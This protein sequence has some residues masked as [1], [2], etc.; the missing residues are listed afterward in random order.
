MISSKDKM[1]N[2][3]QY[4]SIILSY[5]PTLKNQAFIKRILTI[6]SY[7]LIPILSQYN[8]SL[9]LYESQNSHLR[10]NF[11]SITYDELFFEVNLRFLK[12]KVKGKKNIFCFLI[13]SNFKKY[14][15]FIIEFISS[16]PKNT[17]HYFSSSPVFISK[18]I[19]HNNKNFVYISSYKPQEFPLL[20]LKIAVD[21]PI[22][23]VLNKKRKLRIDKNNNR[24]EG[25]TM[26]CNTRGIWCNDNESQSSNED[27]EE[28][29]FARNILIYL[30]EKVYRFIQRNET[31]I[32][33]VT[34]YI[35]KVLSRKG[36]LIKHKNIERRVY[37]I[38]NVMKAIGVIAKKKN[39]IIV[40]IENDNK[41]NK[42]FLSIDN[43]IYNTDDNNNNKE[44]TKSSIEKQSD[45]ITIL[46]LKKSIEEKRAKLLQ[47]SRE[48]L[49]YKCLISKNKLEL[50][51]K[52]M[53]NGN[54]NKKVFFPLYL[55]KSNSAIENQS[56]ET[57]SKLVLLSKEKIDL[58]KPKDIID[59]IM[60]D[61]FNMVILKDIISEDIYK[62]IEENNLLSSDC[63]MKQT[64]CNEGTN[65][66]ES[67]SY[68]KSFE[69][70]IDS[71]S[72]NEDYSH[73][74]ITN[75]LFNKHEDTLGDDGKEIY[76]DYFSSFK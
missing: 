75:I 48:L 50:D 32:N 20:V 39:S 14:E 18:K 45:Q 41:N 15:P 46:I 4:P 26:P 13:N 56:K 43:S 30:T 47:L 16:F 29:I 21:V 11:I 6:M 34:N 8:N 55:M 52:P 58:L 31:E 65:N 70:I 35:L 1:G 25:E 53:S 76:Y 42:E 63:S 10:H 67:S 27:L 66:K 12:E 73:M 68:E 23:S 72:L 38:I 36:Q 33:E 71:D 37:D 49:F 17:F 51:S 60:A 28:Q 57:N 3:E 44:K 24:L 69:M 61:N 62:Y 54:E 64:A 9:N 5:K 2:Y 40:F 19:M 74:N 59:Q 22:T 7:P